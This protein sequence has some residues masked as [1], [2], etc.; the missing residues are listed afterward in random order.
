MYHY[1]DLKVEVQKI[2]RNVSVISFVIGAL[3][4]ASEHLRMWISKLRTPRIIALL[5]KAG[6]WDN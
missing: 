2:Y 3:G 6:T 4:S 5:Q 1:Q